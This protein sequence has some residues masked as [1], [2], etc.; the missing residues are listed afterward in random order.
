MTYVVEGS[1]WHKD[2]KGNAEELGRGAIQFMSAGTGVSHSEANHGG[3][4]LRFVQSWIVP[5]KR[6]LAMRDGVMGDFPDAT[7]NERTKIV[8]E[9][10]VPPSPQRAPPPLRAGAPVAPCPLG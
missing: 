7:I 8:N 5:R 1:L 4:P 3:K 6:G 9:L 10:C 2:S